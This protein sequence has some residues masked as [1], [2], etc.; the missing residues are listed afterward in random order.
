MVLQLDALMRSWL[1]FAPLCKPLLDK[2]S[3]LEI[4]K[5]CL[6]AFSG[7]CC[8]WVALWCWDG[9]WDWFHQHWQS[10]L[11][12]SCVASRIVVDHRSLNLY[13]IFFLGGEEGSF[14]HGQEVKILQY[15]ASGWLSLGKD[16][17]VDLHPRKLT[18]SPEKGHFKRKVVFQP[19]FFSGHVSF[20]GSKVSKGSQMKRCRFVA[21]FLHLWKNQAKDD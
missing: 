11:N 14:S 20:R 4:F 9:T 15:F 1:E 10:K 8:S 16:L 13:I 5:R 19:C 12:F 18:C 21:R 6:W 3:V 7:A 17:L 2:P